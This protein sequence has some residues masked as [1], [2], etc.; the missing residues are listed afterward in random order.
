EAEQQEATI[1][2]LEEAEI[3]AC[4]NLTDSEKLEST[5][6]HEQIAAEKAL[7]DLKNGLGLLRTNFTE[8][9]QSVFTKLQPLGITEIP[10]SNVS[11]M[12][13]S[14][15]ERLKA[16]QGQVKKKTEIETQI[17][18]LDSELQRL[19]AVIETQGT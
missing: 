3:T 7:A 19:D 14:L 18:D 17:A 2:K 16:W 8:M 4:K 1:K 15:R 5:A 12:L 10:D 6:A 9:K 13:N 11:S